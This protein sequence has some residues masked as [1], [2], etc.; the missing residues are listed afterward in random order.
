MERL[1]P[2]YQRNP[3]TCS[4]PYP[5]SCPIFSPAN[6]VMFVLRV[7]LGA[8]LLRMVRVVD[9]RGLLSLLSSAEIKM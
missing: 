9:L 8:G 1:D 4:F 7:N 5:K 2:I 6:V 3:G